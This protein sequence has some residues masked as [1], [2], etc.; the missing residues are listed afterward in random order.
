[1]PMQYRDSS[2]KDVLSNLL[3]KS[4]WLCGDVDLAFWVSF[5]SVFERN[6]FDDFGETVHRKMR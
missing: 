4:F 5:N 3:F 2:L 6:A 1:M